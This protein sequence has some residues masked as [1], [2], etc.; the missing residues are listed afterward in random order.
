MCA[1]FSYVTTWE[2]LEESLSYTLIHDS[3]TGNN[4]S[5]AFSVKEQC[6]SNVFISC[7]HLSFLKGATDLIDDVCC[8]VPWTTVH[9]ASL[10]FT[11]SLS[12]LKLMS[13]ESVMSS[14]HLIL[15]CPHLLLPSIFPSIRVFSN[16]SGLHSRWPKYHSFSIS[17]FNELNSR[18]ISFRID[19]FDLL[20]LQGT[21][22]SLLQ[23]ILKASVET[24]RAQFSP[25]LTFPFSELSIQNTHFAIL[26]DLSSQD[27][28]YTTWRW[29]GK[30]SSRGKAADPNTDQA[31]PL[32]ISSK[33][34]RTR[35][36]YISLMAFS[37]FSSVA[38]L[39]LTFCDPM[40]CSMLSL[41]VHHQLPEFTQTHVR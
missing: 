11:I 27:N 21:L 17:P 2:G 8:P 3:H 12:L 24:E 34:F 26:Q 25:S 4:Q 40:D 22:K 14:N 18:L 13:T 7:L 32:F 23:H 39:C 33:F 30:F 35:R 29:V 28:L 20:A 19:W 41:P 37:K 36:E 31:V 5:F 6:G 15:C 16:K 9:Q 38:Q 10:P 1:S